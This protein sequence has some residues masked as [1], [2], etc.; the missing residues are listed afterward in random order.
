MNETNIVKVSFLTDAQK[1]VLRHFIASSLPL[2]TYVKKYKYAGQALQKM[3][4]P[5]IQTKQVT[6]E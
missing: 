4:A 1:F 6:Y 2:K 5:N 3:L